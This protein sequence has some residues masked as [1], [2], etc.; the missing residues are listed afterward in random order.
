MHVFRNLLLKTCSSATKIKHSRYK[1]STYTAAAMK[2]VYEKVV[3]K[4][5]GWRQGTG[6]PICSGVIIDGTCYWIPLNYVTPSQIDE[7]CSVGMNGGRAAVLDNYRSYDMVHQLIKN[8]FGFP[9]NDNER[10]GPWAGMNVLRNGKDRLFEYYA[11][12]IILSRNMNLVISMKI[13]YLFSDI[14]IK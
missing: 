1:G 13:S 8:T 10:E 5:N 6:P 2:E 14:G 4:S 11:H 7:V 12:A 9:E 3:S